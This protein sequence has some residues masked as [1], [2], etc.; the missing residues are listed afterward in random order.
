MKISEKLHYNNM[1]NNIYLPNEIFT[2]IQKSLDTGIKRAFAYS[3]YY[4]VTYLYRYAKYKHDDVNF[5]QKELVSLLGYSPSNMAK[6]NPIIKSGG[7][8]EGLGY[9]TNTTDFPIDWTMDEDGHLTFTNV[10][11]ARKQSVTPN[12]YDKG[13]TYKIKKPLK[14]FHRTIES[15]H[16]EVYDGTFY[17]VF[18]THK[19]PVKHFM[20]CM[21]CGDLGTVGFYLYSY[22][23]YMNHLHCKS[24]VY[25]TR[26]KVA[27]DI[28]MSVRS[29]STYLQRLDNMRLL[30]VNGQGFRMTNVIKPTR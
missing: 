17:E 14:A 21:D 20:A 28:G 9:I 30:N 16:E 24:G 3:F 18:N 15:L 26:E 10:K 6:V 25:A 13:K 5:G 4:L 2:D 29:V 22:I 27:D 19:I 11:E 23:I 7:I 1:E 8:L 12:L